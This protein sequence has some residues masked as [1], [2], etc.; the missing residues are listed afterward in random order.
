MPGGAA[1]GDS[2]RVGRH[3]RGMPQSGS[4]GGPSGGTSAD[5]SDSDLDLLRLR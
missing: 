2:V 1:P 3:R 4:H 5:D